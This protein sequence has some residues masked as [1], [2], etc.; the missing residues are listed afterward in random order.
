MILRLEFR[1]ISKHHLDV[2]QRL[3]IRD[4]AIGLLDADTPR[5]GFTAGV[6]VIQDTEWSLLTL[7]RMANDVAF[8][9]QF[10]R[11]RGANLCIGAARESSEPATAKCECGNL[12]RTSFAQP[13]SWNPLY[14]AN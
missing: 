6:P 7:N 12:C 1:A 8:K 11:R 9:K 5:D 3:V 14:R 13:L 10:A 2:L 4:R